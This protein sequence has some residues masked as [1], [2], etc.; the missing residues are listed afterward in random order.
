MMFFLIDFTER[1]FSIFCGVVGRNRLLIGF[2]HP[3]MKKNVAHL[4]QKVTSIIEPP[5][6][7]GA[8]RAAKLK[9][10]YGVFLR[11]ELFDNFDSISVCFAIPLSANVA[12]CSGVQFVE[13]DFRDWWVWVR[14]FLFILPFL[15]CAFYKTCPCDTAVV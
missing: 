11:I 1:L 8:I 13:F 5:F 7:R 9:T 10:I 2:I 4:I 3:Q 12:T 14:V 6:H 15:F